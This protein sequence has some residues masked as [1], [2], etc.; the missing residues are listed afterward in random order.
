V[1]IRD[2]SPRLEVGG[3]SGARLLKAPSEPGLFVCTHASG[4]WALDLRIEWHIERLGRYCFY[5]R[6]R[7]TCELPNSIGL[8]M[9]EEQAQYSTEVQNMQDSLPAG[10]EI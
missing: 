1:K 10:G 4:W 6:E 5:R 8:F 3:F 2:D 7:F 9:C